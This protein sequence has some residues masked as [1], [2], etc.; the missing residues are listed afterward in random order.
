MLKAKDAKIKK[1][2]PGYRKDRYQKVAVSPFTIIQA[3]HWPRNGYCK[4]TATG[5]SSLSSLRRYDC[6]QR[7][8]ELQAE[9][10]LA[11]RTLGKGGEV[12]TFVATPQGRRGH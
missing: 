11:T 6:H 4:T 1:Q 3:A 8:G 2:L 5:W 10:L 7:Q 12:V 9:D